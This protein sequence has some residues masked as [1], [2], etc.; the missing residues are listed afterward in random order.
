[1]VQVN[2]QPPLIFY[3]TH[4]KFYIPPLKFYIS[5]PKFYIP[6]PKFYITPPKFYIYLTCNAV[7]TRSARPLPPGVVN[8]GVEPPFPV[9]TRKGT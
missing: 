3:T 4:L 1:M 2:V 5:P 6:P 8:C 9:K 7:N